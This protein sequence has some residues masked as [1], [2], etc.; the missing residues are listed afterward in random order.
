MHTKFYSV[1]LHGGTALGMEGL[2]EI[3]YEGVDCIHMQ[4]MGCGG[5]DCIQM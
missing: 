3:G 5:V 1:D 4:E 2:Q